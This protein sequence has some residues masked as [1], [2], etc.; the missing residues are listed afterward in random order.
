MSGGVGVSVSRE[1]IR[2]LM[3]PR[4]FKI[5]CRTQLIILSW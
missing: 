1:A 5:L 4:R 3:P 2:T